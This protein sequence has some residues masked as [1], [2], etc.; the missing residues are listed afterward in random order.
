MQILRDYYDQFNFLDTNLI[1]FDPSPSG[2]SVALLQQY[3]F[4]FLLILIL[5]FLD[6]CG[7]IFF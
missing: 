4:N 2:F 1:F 5:I 6:L 3:W 7:L